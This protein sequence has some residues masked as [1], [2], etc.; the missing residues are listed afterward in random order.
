VGSVSSWSEMASNMVDN[1][2]AA[3]ETRAVAACHGTGQ[4]DVDEVRELADEA[5]W[6]ILDDNDDAARLAKLLGVSVDELRTARH[7]PLSIKQGREGTG[8]VEG[9]LL[10]YGAPLAMAAAKGAATF[11]GAQVART[12][13]VRFVLPRIRRRNRDAVGPEDKPKA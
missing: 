1:N 4:A 7:V 12:L 3:D 5:W 10:V 2:M 8:V 11:I 9:A 13:W 6:E